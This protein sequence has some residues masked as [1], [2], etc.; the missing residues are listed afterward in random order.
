[1]RYVTLPTIRVTVK[2]QIADGE[3]VALRLT[4]RD[5][6]QG[7]LLGILPTGTQVTW[8][9]IVP[10]SFP[11]LMHPARGPPLLTHSIRSCPP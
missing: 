5:T 7:E 4:R 11:A 9:R 2:D 10:Q 6:H 3:T 1:M 8:T